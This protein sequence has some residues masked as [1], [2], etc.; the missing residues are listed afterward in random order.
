MRGSFDAFD[1]FDVSSNRVCRS[2]GLRDQYF[3]NVRRRLFKSTVTFV[4]VLKN[5]E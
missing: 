3:R 2:S 1:R 4:Y 5:A